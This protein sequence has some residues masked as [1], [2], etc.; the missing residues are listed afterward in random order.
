M[1]R[2]PEKFAVGSGG[3]ADR[4]A[5]RRWTPVKPLAHCIG[6]EERLRRGPSARVGKVGVPASPIADAGALHAR[7]CG[8][9]RQCDSRRHS[10]PPSIRSSGL[11]MT[12]VDY[13]D[14]YLEPTA[15]NPPCQDD[16]SIT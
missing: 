13:S 10:C 15:D 1:Q 7:I 9:L 2:A 3:V 14:R 16:R 8:D 11:T 4:G 5:G 12:L 6:I